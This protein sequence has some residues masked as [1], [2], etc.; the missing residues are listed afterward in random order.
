MNRDLAVVAADKS[1]AEALRG[2]LSRPEA[3]G[4]RRIQPPTIVEHPNRDPGVWKTGHELLAVYAHDHTHGLILLDHAWDGNPHD[5][6][7]DLAQEIETDCR[8]VWEDRARCIVIA[9]ELEAWVWSRSPHVAEVLKWDDNQTLRAWLHSQGLW[10]EGQ[11]KPADPKDAYHAALRE[12]RM[13]PSAALFR[14]LAETV[15]LSSCQ[16]PA[17][18]RLLKTLRTWF[19]PS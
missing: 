4:M 1:M 15:S 19:P 5:S 11:I 8:R 14:K 13:P 3:I 10:E 18:A 12:K 16:D 7:A 2:M 6:P 9:P 17:F